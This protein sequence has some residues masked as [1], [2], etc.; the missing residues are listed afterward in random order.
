MLAYFPQRP[1]TFLV[2][3]YSWETALLGAVW[4][5]AVCVVCVVLW[6]VLILTA[7]DG[8]D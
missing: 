1:P 7:R 5:V 2:M 4:F 8:E 3:T 6:L